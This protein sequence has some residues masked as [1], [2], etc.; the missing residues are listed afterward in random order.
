MNDIGYFELDGIKSSDYDLYI[1]ASLTFSSPQMKGEFVEVSGLD[2]E[3]FLSDGKLNN[4]PKSFPAFLI[5][6]EGFSHQKRATQISNWLKSSFKWRDLTFS[7]DAEY[8]YKVLCTN[9]YDIEATLGD[10]GKTIITFTS[11]PY[12]F[13]KT[14]LVE[15]D[16]KNSINN[17]TKRTARPRIEIEG[18]GNIEIKIGSQICK[19]KNVDGG[20]ILDSLYNQCTSLDGQRAQWDKLLTYPLIEISRGLNAVSITGNVTSSKIIPRFEEVV[21]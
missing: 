2:G 15:I 21:G 11:K 18:T 3:Y 12:K 19:L 5:L 1:D 16:L 17:L 8:I 4:V 6:S 7:G 13:L 14:G 9:E 20:I 10:Y